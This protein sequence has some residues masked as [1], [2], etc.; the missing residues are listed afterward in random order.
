MEL[1]SRVISQGIP[2]TSYLILSLQ[3][4]DTNNGDENE[5]ENDSDELLMT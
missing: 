5:N 2:H 1:L 4:R 3:E